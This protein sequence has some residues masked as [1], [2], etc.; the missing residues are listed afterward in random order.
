MQYQ[1]G[2]ALTEG[3]IVLLCVLT[4]FAAITW[5][6][7]LQDIALHEQHASRF[8][9]FELARAGNIN[10]AQLS[11]RFFQGRHAGWRRQQGDALL[12]ADGIQVTHNRQAQLDSLSQPGG[13]DRN[14]TLLRREWRLQDNGIVN[15]S[16]RIRP[17]AAAPSGQSSVR[18]EPQGSTVGFLNRLAVTLRRHTAILIDAGHTIDA[19]A[20]HERA[21][22]SKVAWQQTAHASYAAGKKIAAAAMPVDAPW[23]RPAPVFDWFMPWAG[24]KP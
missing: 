24:K 5:L 8:G 11:S 2:Q 14:A 9:A 17:R 6:G 23:R 10:N 22:R 18:D 7:R 15:V 3:L 1:R 19:R 12:T 13:V 20:A 4:F 21:A 16:L